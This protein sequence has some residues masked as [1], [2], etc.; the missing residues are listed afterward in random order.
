MSL[1]RIN[2]ELLDLGRYVFLLVAAVFSVEGRI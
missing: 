1:K 2:K